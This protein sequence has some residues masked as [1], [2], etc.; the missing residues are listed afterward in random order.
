VVK[1]KLLK[2]LLALTEVTSIPLLV[3][4][5]IYL[6][7]GYQMLSSSLRLIPRAR[8]VHTDPVLRALLAAMALVHG[9]SGL[10]VLCERRIKSGSLKKL[11]EFLVTGLLVFFAA[12]F[13]TLEITV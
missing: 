8:L 13:G 5:L 6:L 4:G 7:T 10:I 11:I 2:T 12:L 3:L 1:P 9:Y